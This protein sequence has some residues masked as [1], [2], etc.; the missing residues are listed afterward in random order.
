[1]ERSA[2]QWRE[3]FS[4]RVANQMRGWL[5]KGK[6]DKASR[7]TGGLSKEIGVMYGRWAPKPDRQM[8]K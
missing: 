1:M 4:K 8:A 6:G 7:E 2:K 3:W 5:S